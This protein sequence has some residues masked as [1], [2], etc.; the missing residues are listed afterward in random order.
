VQGTY[1]NE[2][3]PDAADW[4]EGLIAAGVIPDGYVDRRDVR[5]VRPDDL[6]GYVQCHF[7]AGIGGWPAALRQVGWR[8]DRPVWTASLP[9]QPFSRAGRRKGFADERHLWPC[10]EKLV[11]ARRPAVILGEQSADA[12]DWIGV[13]RGRLD[14][15]EYAVGAIPFEAACAGAEHRRARYYFVADADDEPR[16]LEQQQRGSGPE[17]AW[18]ESR[19]RGTGEPV[20]D[21]QG[22][23]ER[24][25][26]LSGR[27][28][29]VAPGGPGAGD[30]L[31]WLVDR[32]GKARRAPPGICGLA[33]GLS[34]RV[35]RL[36][37]DGETHVYARVAALR[38]FGNALD[39]RAA[40]AFV[41]SCM[42]ILVPMMGW[43]ILATLLA[44]AAAM[45][46]S[47]GGS[48]G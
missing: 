18:D 13:M 2:H 33:P 46:A 44:I 7:F 15:L 11:E 43:G 20:G 48:W 17:R 45:V 36:R 40:R 47:G 22:D 28:R 4:L 42:D 26:R 30:G 25:A 19:W 34:G 1:Y 3:D 38:G 35:A 29:Q 16:R 31:E 14:S 12:T 41:A 39:L 24:G 27:A 9:C 21:A 32:H 6:R 37:A 5:D 10:F 23:D 8:D